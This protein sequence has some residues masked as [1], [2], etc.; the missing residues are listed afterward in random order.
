[1]FKTIVFL[2]C[3]ILTTTLSAGKGLDRLIT[4]NDRYVHDRLEHP[5]R[6]AERRE[7]LVSS[8]SPFAVIIGCSDSRVPPE[9]IFDQ[10]VG[11]LFVVRVAGNVIGPIELSSV[12][13]AAR[14]LGSSVIL[15]MGH[16][17]CGAVK[18]VVDGQV[19]KIE[20]IAEIIEPAIKAV[21]V[22]HPKDLLNSCIKT[23]AVRMKQILLKSP[24]IQALIKEGK[25]EI[26]AAYYNL[27]T[28]AVELL[29]SNKF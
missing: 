22:D 7:S 24:V 25:L 29:D 23:N 2:I 6:T 13:Y 26:S 8:Q 14:N 20:P 9:I 15:V 11:D 12:E 4:G 17:N 10:G 21:E 3:C 18:A 1:M 27:E 28:G 19:S 5:N 16:K